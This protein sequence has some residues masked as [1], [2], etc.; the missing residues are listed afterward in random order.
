MYGRRIGIPDGWMLAERARRIRQV[1]AHEEMK[2]KRVQ[3]RRI[4]PPGKLPHHHRAV[5]GVPEYRQNTRTFA[6]PESWAICIKRFNHYFDLLS[7]GIHRHFTL[8][9]ELLAKR[10]KTVVSAANSNGGLADIAPRRGGARGRKLSSASPTRG[11]GG[12]RC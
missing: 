1:A 8:Q 11:F 12:R 9:D 10:I 5:G 6:S 3:T 4:A 2:R 7:V